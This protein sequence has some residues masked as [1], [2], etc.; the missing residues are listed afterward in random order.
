MTRQIEHAAIRFDCV[1]TGVERA[2]PARGCADPLRGLFGQIK[3]AA[4]RLD[5]AAARVVQA[6]PARGC[7]GLL[8]DLFVWYVCSFDF[9]PGGV[10][11]MEE[12]AKFSSST[13]GLS[14]NGRF[15]FWGYI[16]AWSA[17]LVKELYVSTLLD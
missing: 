16:Q 7:A 14:Q 12:G 10:Q 8:R 15:L 4:V 1:A 5:C 2:D 11:G 9:C 6:N 13:Q 3:R 17:Q